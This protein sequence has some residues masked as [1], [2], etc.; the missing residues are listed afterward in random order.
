MRTS[1][2]AMPT[3]YVI[4]T[5]K[6]LVISSGWGC[7]TCAEILA[8]RKQLVSHPDFDPKFDQLVDGRSVTELDMTMDEAKKIASSSPFSPE[9]RRAFVASSLLVLGFARLME[10][11]SKRGEGREQVRVFHDLPSA[12]SWLGLD[13]IPR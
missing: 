6:R 5:E 11:H 2:H 1:A 8:H 3:R 13:A 10:T 12:L 7:V 9:S 4:D